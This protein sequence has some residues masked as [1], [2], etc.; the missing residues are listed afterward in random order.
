MPVLLFS[1]VGHRCGDHQW[2]HLRSRRSLRTWACEV[3]RDDVDAACGMGMGTVDA[4]VG[5]LVV[6]LL[7]NGVRLGP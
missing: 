1:A 4:Q 7:M 2:R 5:F 6:L 3:D